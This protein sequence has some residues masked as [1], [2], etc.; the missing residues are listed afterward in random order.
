MCCDNIAHFPY[1]TFLY[2]FHS[3]GPVYPSAEERAASNAYLTGLPSLARSGDVMVDATGKTTLVS[4]G[5][6]KDGSE[7]WMGMKE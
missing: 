3:S 2:L 7:G 1:L 4:E 6:E 5:K